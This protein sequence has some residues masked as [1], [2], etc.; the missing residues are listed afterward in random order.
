MPVY[1]FECDECG[2]IEEYFV[3]LP[4]SLP[5]KCACGKK[6][7]LNKLE[8]FSSSKPILKVQG[9]YETDYKNRR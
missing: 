1:D 6:S 7:K 4:N 3:P 2:K 9:S 5:E 8:T